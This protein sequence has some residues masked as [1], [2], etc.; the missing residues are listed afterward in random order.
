MPL[1]WASFLTARP[2]SC[3]EL[4]RIKRDNPGKVISPGLV[5]G[6]HSMCWSL[7]LEN[8]WTSFLHSLPL[9]D[10]DC[11]AHMWWLISSFWQVCDTQIPRRIHFDLYWPVRDFILPCKAGGE[12][13]SILGLADANYYIKVGSFL[14]PTLKQCGPARVMK[15]TPLVSGSLIFCL[16][17]I[18]A[19]VPYLWT[20]LEQSLLTALLLLLV[21]VGR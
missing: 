6:A 16:V 17:G 20:V 12:N 10:P 19:V 4:V 15:S 5:T 13:G 14:S 7:L 9:Y 3:A 18:S 8:S 2:P 1:T 11:C 21:T